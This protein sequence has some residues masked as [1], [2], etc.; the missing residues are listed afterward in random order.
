MKDNNKF[1]SIM[2]EITQGLSGD[3]TADREYLKEQL[4]KYKSHPLS[5]E[6]IRAIS[7]L[8]VDTIPEDN[9][10]KISKL[11]SNYETGINQTLEEARFLIYK[12]DYDKALRIM[13]ALVDD[14]EEL[15][16][17]HDDSVSEY[18]IFREFFEEALYINIANPQK[19]IRY[20]TIPYPDI[21]SLYGG[22]LFEVKR[23]TDAQEALMKGLRWN[24]VHFEIYGEYIETFKALEDHEKFFQLSKDAFKIAFRPSHLARCYRN[25]GYYFIEMKM[26]DV[27]S[28]CYLLSMQYEQ[29]KQAQSELYYIQSITN[30]TIPQFTEE[31]M[32][33]YGDMFGFPIGPDNTLLELAVGYGVHCVERG[34]R[35]GARYCLQIA[36]DLTKSEYIKQYLDDLAK[37]QA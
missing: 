23:Y 28:A 35:E 34:E 20:A 30:T 25:L 19:E 33:E 31:Q 10:E 6:I 9:K 22:L 4:E 18:H 8:L 24:P 1:H 21:Y 15:D 26:W 37:P 17:F 29:S 2:M 36:Y 27:A 14:V 12:K 16:W 32:Q 7:R 5:T 3:A 13:E 11:I